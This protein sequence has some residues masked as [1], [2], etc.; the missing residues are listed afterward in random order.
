MAQYKAVGLQTNSAFMQ[1]FGNVVGGDDTVIPA[2]ALVLND[3]VD[4]IRV[5]GGTRLQSLFQVNGDFDTGATLQYSLGYR[6]CDAGGVLVA[7]ATYF[8]AAG[9]TTLQAPVT[10]SA[11]TRFAFAPIDFNEDVFITMTVTAGATGVAG[12]PS[13]TTYTL[14]IA[15][16]VK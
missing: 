7:N 4:L 13:I 16:G 11:P 15:R 8:A 5:A 3:T 2:I 14:G 12:T 10:G 6:P 9:Q 1:A